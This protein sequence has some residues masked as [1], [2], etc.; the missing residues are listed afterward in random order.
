MPR[1]EGELQTVS[2]RLSTIP[3]NF[4][5]SGRMIEVQNA[6]E[7]DEREGDEGA[8]GSVPAEARREADEDEAHDATEDRDEERDLELPGRLALR[9][10]ST[11]SE[12]FMRAKTRS[13]R[14]EVAEARSLMSPAKAR[15]DTMTASTTMETYGVRRDR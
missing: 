9:S 5:R 11:M 10:F 15:Q 2:L 8:F 14:S 3:A 4:D 12:A 6:D 13:R 7:D 1:S